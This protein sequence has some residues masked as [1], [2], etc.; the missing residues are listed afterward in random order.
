[1]PQVLP[2]QVGSVGLC[3]TG[4]HPRNSLL[5]GSRGPISPCTDPEVVGW[6]EVKH[7]L[8]YEAVSGVKDFSWSS[9]PDAELM[10]HLGRFMAPKK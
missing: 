6:E 5:L 4:N 3:G 7:P 8:T 2:G 10:F 9:G 1:M